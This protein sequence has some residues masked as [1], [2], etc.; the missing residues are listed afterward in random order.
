M[1]KHSKGKTTTIWKCSTSRGLDAKATSITQTQAENKVKKKKDTHNIFPTP[2]PKS[3]EAQEKR[4]RR[5]TDKKK[6][7]E[8]LLLY[9]QRLVEEKGLPPSRLMLEQADKVPEP[10]KAQRELHKEGNFDKSGET[11]WPGVKESA[12][13]TGEVKCLSCRKMFETEHALSNHVYLRCMSWGGGSN[14]KCQLFEH[15]ADCCAKKVIHVQK[16]H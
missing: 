11:M 13:Q 4:K 14:V 8:A 12:E 10:V 2:A 1:L 15:I 3:P 6:R 16:E 9:H 7:L 5:K